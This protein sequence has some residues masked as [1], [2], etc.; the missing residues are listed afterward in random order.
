[1]DANTLGLVVV[2]I[3]LFIV[4]AVVRA[5]SNENS[6]QWKSIDILRKA[7]EDLRVDLARVESTAKNTASALDEIK[8]DL[9]A[10]RVDINALARK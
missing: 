1:M 7:N 9:R 6:L 10:I 2:T 5:N 4:G 3:A 8:S